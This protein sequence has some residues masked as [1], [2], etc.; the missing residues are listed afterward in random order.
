MYR[1]PFV[2]PKWDITEA[3]WIDHKPNLRFA[4]FDGGVAAGANDAV[5]DKE[6]GLVWERSPALDRKIWDAAIVYSYAKATAGR[7]SWRLPSIEE[8]LSL[9]DPTQNNPTLP[10]GHPFINVQI[11]YFYWSSTLGWM[12]FRLILGAIILEMLTRV[13]AR[14]MSDYTYGSY[15]E[16]TGMI[17]LI[18]LESAQRRS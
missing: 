7:K 5:F 13:I 17:I 16:D 4:I 6:T 1:R 3:E 9:V 2:S 15:G 11:D 10:V 18:D 14:R 8:L 12:R